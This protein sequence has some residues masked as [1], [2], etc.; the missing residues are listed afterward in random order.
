VQG[1]DSP[2]VGRRR[3]AQE[4]RRL[5][6]AAGLTIADVAAEL[7]CSIG[8]ISR[9]E[10]GA[11]GARIQ[12]VRDMLALYGVTGA[13]QVDLVDLVRLARQRAWWHDYTDVVPADSARFYGLEDGAAGMRQHGVALVPG[14]LQTPDYA[15]AVISAPADVPTADVERR[16]ELRLRRQ[17]LLDRP[18]PPR[19]HV[20]LDEAALRR[21]IGGAAVMAGQLGRL[22]E[23]AQRPHVRMQV[24]PFDAGGYSAVGVP[25]TVF[26][27]PDPADRQVVF[28]EQL[29]RNTLLDEPAEVRHYTVAFDQAVELALDPAAS[30]AF[31]RDVEVSMR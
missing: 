19:L 30:A 11:V 21:S 25:F 28:L 24:L 31:L 2:A 1:T 3:L 4:L 9:I 10:T 18:Q 23:L 20:L 14:L 27:F 12:D 6:L 22:I 15:R 16:I 7:E 17:R 29:T 8:K 5:R 26:G 13:R